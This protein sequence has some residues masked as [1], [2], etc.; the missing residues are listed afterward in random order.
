METNFQLESILCVNLHDY[1]KRLLTKLCLD[2]SFMCLS[3]FVAFRV[4]F[5][6]L[7][8]GLLYCIDLWLTEQR[9]QTNPND[10]VSHFKA[11]VV[12]C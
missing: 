5:N 3:R 6:E 9:W 7:C 2:A 1:L 4:T 8:C 10:S 12:V 11:V